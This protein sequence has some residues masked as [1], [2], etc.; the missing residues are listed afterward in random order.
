MSKRSILPISGAT[1][2]SQSRPL[3]DVNEEVLRIPQRFSM[4]GGSPSNCLLSYLGHSFAGSYLIAEMQSVDSTATATW[5]YN[6]L[7]KLEVNICIFCVVVK[8]FLSSQSYLAEMIFKQIYSTHRWN[9]NRYNL[10]RSEWT[11]E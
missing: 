7:R 6:E 4:T 10:S 9:P 8:V 2:P 3:N 5:A 1:T 11:W